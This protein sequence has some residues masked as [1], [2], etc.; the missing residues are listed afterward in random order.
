MHGGMCAIRPALKP[1]LHPGRVAVAARVY[2]EGRGFS[3]EAPEY[4]RAVSVP[5]RGPEGAQ[6]VESDDPQ[7]ASMVQPHF[8][9]VDIRTCLLC[10]VARAVS[11]MHKHLQ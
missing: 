7:E 11:I 3:F 5:S 8:R 10:A 9:G 1:L 6:A 4:L 2:G